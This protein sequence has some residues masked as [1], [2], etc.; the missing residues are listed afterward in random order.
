M[1]TNRTLL[2]EF[3]AVNVN[4]KS[5]CDRFLRP[6]SWIPSYSDWRHVYKLPETKR[7]RPK[8]WLAKHKEGDARFVP[9]SETQHTSDYRL[10]K[11]HRVYHTT[12]YPDFWSIGDVVLQEDYSFAVNSQLF[13]FENS[14]YAKEIIPLLYA[15]GRA[16][17]FVSRIL[18][19]DSF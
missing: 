18:P 19:G 6:A 1:V 11:P 2:W 15:E 7:V 3:D 10:F 12:Q 17:L 5:D 9:L 14:T 4:L 8:P 16:F 13:G